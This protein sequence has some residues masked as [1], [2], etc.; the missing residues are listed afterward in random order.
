LDN[1]GTAT[2]RFTRFANMLIDGVRWATRQKVVE[3]TSGLNVDFVIQGVAA[4]LDYLRPM[5]RERRS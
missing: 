5:V 2:K 1:W 3:R 4:S